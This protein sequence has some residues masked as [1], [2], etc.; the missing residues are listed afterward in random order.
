MSR[1]VAPLFLV[2]GLLA[3]SLPASAQRRN[4]VRLPREA[5]EHLPGVLDLFA[6]PNASAPPRIR[7]HEFIPG[8]VV[9]RFGLDMT[10][11]EIADVARSVGARRIE[12]L[13]PIGLFLVHGPPS[14]RGLE[15]LMERLWETDTA[16]SIEPNYI[17]QLAF[18][19]ND[20]HHVNGNQWYHEAPSDIDLDLRSAW[21]VTRGSSD[22]I[23]AVVDTGTVN[24]HPEFVGRFFVNLGEIPD[25]GIDDDG[26][27]YVDDVSGWNAVDVN[28]DTEDTTL[29]HGTW[30]ASI[31]LANTD[32]SHQ[33]AGFDHFARYLPSN[34]GLRRAVRR[35]GR[36]G[37]GIG[38]PDLEP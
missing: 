21:D 18:Q 5:V 35:G 13:S 22:V 16:V 3:A 15:R 27:G 28:G 31:L 33:V 25:N 1:R 4:V 6:R 17:G 14:A 38:L 20:P 19:P 24:D 26:N 8:E 11:E 9:V 36:S 37:S 23:V 30:V 12:R 32:N 10:D 29:G 34:Q 7:N 2:F